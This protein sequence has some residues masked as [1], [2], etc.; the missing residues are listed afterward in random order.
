MKNPLC[1]ICGQEY[2]VDPESG[3]FFCADCEEIYGSGGQGGWYN[4]LDVD[5]DD[6][7]DY[8]NFIDVITPLLNHQF[9]KPKEND[10]NWQQ[11]SD[12]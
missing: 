7:G 9:G 10:D 6:E 8:D 2:G 12:C 11:E 3:L 1:S 5:D 4:E